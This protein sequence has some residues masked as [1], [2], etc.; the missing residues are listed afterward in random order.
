LTRPVIHDAAG[1]KAEG[2][3]KLSEAQSGRA[4]VELIYDRPG[5]AYPLLID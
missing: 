2:E 4:L 5:L 3:Y 1:K